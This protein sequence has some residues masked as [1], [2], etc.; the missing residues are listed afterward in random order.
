MK[1]VRLLMS[2]FGPYGGKTEIDFERLGDAGLYLITGDTGA[3]KTT[4]FDAIVFALYGEA[5]G[6][7]RRADMFRSKYAGEQ[8]PTF[9]EF[10]F[11]YRD[12][13]YTVRRNPEYL[14]A[15][16]RGNG[17]TMQKADAVL[18][19]SDGRPPVTRTGEVN[20]EIIALIGLDRKQFT[21]IAMIAQGDFQKLLLAGT[22]ERSGIFRQI[23]GTG[24]YQRIQERL[25]EAA[26]EQ[27]EAY[28][29][30][31]RSI[32]Q[33]LD[34][35]VCGEMP[36]QEAPQ[37]EEGDGAQAGADA[38]TEGASGREISVGAQEAFGE[39][40][41]DV[42]RRLVELKRERFEGRIGEGAALLEELCRQEEILL[43]SLDGRLLAAEE[44][45]QGQERLIGT[46]QRLAQQRAELAQCQERLKELEPELSH[47]QALC[48]EA[49]R[50]AREGEKLALEISGRQK[51]MEL[52]DR[53]E[54]EQE[55]LSQKQQEIQQ[56]AGKRQELER[57]RDGLQKS[58]REDE[59][60]I[61]ILASAGEEKERL[62]HERDWLSERQ[63]R[64]REQMQG[65]DQEQ[66]ALSGQ[67]QRVCLRQERI[68][69]LTE[70]I[71]GCEQQAASL[72][73]AE[74]LLGEAG[75][76][77]ERL[78]ERQSSLEQT[79]QQW[80]R[81]LEEAEQA[82]E[83]LEAV[84]SE[85]RAQ[86]QAQEK[87][88]REREAL[89]ASAQ[90]E[91]RRGQLSQQ[92][93][94]RL[95]TFRK[96]RQELEKIRK[97][98]GEQEAACQ[99]L[100]AQ[101]HM[102]RR[103]QD[104][105]RQEWESLRDAQARQLLAQQQAARQEEKGQKRGSLRQ[106]LE[107]CGR[108]YQELLAARQQYRQAVLLKDRLG[109]AYRQ[110]E[111]RFLDAQAGMLAQS[112]E[113]GKACPVCG[114]CHHPSPAGRIQDAPQKEELSR[115]RERLSRA[116]ASAERLSERAGQ[117]T[118]QV[119]ERRENV[120]ALA[121]E[122]FPKE[123]RPEAGFSGEDMGEWL[124]ALW[125]ELARQ[126]SRAL[127][128][129]EELTAELERS[130]RELSRRQEL[131]ALLEEQETVLQ[132]QES[133]LREAEQALAAAGGQREEK[134]K[135]WREFLKGLGDVPGYY[136][137]PG[138]EPC[139]AGVWPQA[140]GAGL[141]GEGLGEPDYHLL[142][143][144][145]QER[146]RESRLLHR[147]AREAA[148]RLALLEQEETAAEQHRQHIGQQLA[149]CQEEAAGLRGQ[150]LARKRQAR[151]E[152]EKARELVEEAGRWLEACAAGRSPAQQEAAGMETDWVRTYERRWQEE[153]ASQAD[154]PR[155]ES[156]SQVLSFMKYALDA[157][158]DC[159]D[160]LGE[161]VCRRNHL[162]QEGQK[163]REELDR[164][165]KEL[166]RLEREEEACRSR[167]Q[168]K[169]RQLRASVREL[170]GQFGERQAA[171]E[172]PLAGEEAAGL[173]RDF[174]A[175][176]CRELEQRLAEVQSQLAQ[177]R[178]RFLKRQ[179]LETLL[180]RKNQELQEL[181][182]K[183]QQAELTLERFKAE[184]DARQK[185]VDALRGELGGEK[186]E[187][188]RA[189]I[190]EMQNRRQALEKALKD[191][192]EDVLRC[193][194]ARQRLEA[195]AE[196]L[197][198][199]IALAG[200]QGE[201][202]LEEALACRD[203]W[204]REKKQIGAERDR[205]ASAFTTNRELSRRV[206]KKQ[207]EIEKVE[208]KYAW[209]RALSETAN[210]S[211]SGK[212]KMELETFIQTTYF[213]R[214]ILRANRRLLTMS[215]GQYELKRQQEGENRQKKAGLD[216]SVIDHY[217]GSERS[218]K[219]LSGGESFQASLSLALGLSDEIQSNAGGIRLD[220]MFVDEGFGSLDEEALAQ[221]MKA[222]RRLTEGNRLVGIISHVS[223]LREQIDK[224]ILVTK[225][226]SADGVT[227]QAQV[228][229]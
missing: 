45:I 106:E 71:S 155:E 179:E 199:Q 126:E 152:A 183:L 229:A 145:L 119:S 34:S 201:L 58:L 202:T 1:P 198:R 159:R 140:P 79:V 137:Q 222:L 172:G 156:F 22:E 49:E 216:L 118:R 46:V 19:F 195:E 189:A 21:Q 168:E 163:K 24:L 103:R 153:R 60:Q 87:R 185:Q 88:D 190:E 30:L 23:F 187:E 111:Q 54:A 223:G 74:P 12:R 105:L 207:G 33:Y 72:G 181:V 97:D 85:E 178:Q 117:L 66:A 13:R 91:P 134:E 215:G 182:R 226:R 51:R 18:S 67:E 186:R 36:L 160:R 142:D 82:G 150:E 109:A 210:G 17:T 16:S 136:P 166:H 52:F 218:V 228:E 122:I 63:G 56:L 180:P 62:T 35:I 188:T 102:Q 93:G 173:T 89:K 95:E 107:T 14:R 203:I 177:S 225:H 125:D 64:L 162:E 44:K 144:F 113:D 146:L 135:Q 96:Q 53:L 86:K 157:L 139:Q 196:T 141:S 209:M 81:L 7:V 20:R 221:A 32:L 8:V 165:Q 73:E 116:E 92:A 43:Q 104:L 132:E 26:K 4:I 15:K 220:S 131:E 38:G 100:R 65:F 194:S 219:T 29:E 69:E 39:G 227:S 9:V 6:D 101:T 149:R 27:R 76:L 197:G 47:R 114:A 40:A 112:L 167:R 41:R 84:L 143:T 115:E 31:Q 124:R 120:Q 184:R 11:A 214:I 164:E 206:R 224:K 5:S 147:Q 211:L 174:A 25:R 78:L 127:R 170:A 129:A 50:Q 2:A 148:E 154:T 48:G 80:E 130:G 169:L 98:A 204:Q 176:L 161:Q 68:R 151:Q 57:A 94:E 133:R 3:G 110:L 171:L 28:R 128:E 59:E 108:Q 123:V 42:S 138:Q 10:T 61:R 99:V 83:R 192:R 37:G 70:A 121:W 191:A 200:E 175:R 193:Q 213:D 212:Q 205:L 55:A 75:R 217:N 208:K 158:T 90:E 77:Q